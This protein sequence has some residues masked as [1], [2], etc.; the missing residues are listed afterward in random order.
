MIRNFFSR[1]FFERAVNSP[2]TQQTILS[3]VYNVLKV[4]RGSFANMGDARSLI[5]QII[6]NFRYLFGFLL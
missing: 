4:I 6:E 2:I 5:Y 3:K 1:S